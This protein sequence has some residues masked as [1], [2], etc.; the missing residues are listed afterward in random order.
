MADYLK[1]AFSYLANS[2]LV[3]NEN[4]FLGSTIYVGTLTLRIKRVIA[5]GG[6]GVVYE[7]QDATKSTCYALKRMLAHDKPTCDLILHEI[8]I[9]KQLS[10]HPNIMRFYSAASVGKEKLKVVGT[11]FLIV[12]EYCRG[13]QLTQYL[14]T[15]RQEKPFSVN[16]I[17]QLMHQ[18]CRAVQHMHSQS[19]PVMHRDLK[20]ENLLLSEEFVIK[21]C[22]FGSASTTSYIPD[23]SWSALKRSV[24][25]EELEKFTTPMYRAPEMLDLYQNFPIGPAADIWALGCILFYLTCTYHPFEDSAK[26]AILNAKYTLPTGS[27][28]HSVFHSLIRQM[29]LI[30]PRQRPTITEVL[31]ELSEL[32]SMREIRV[33]SSI[34]LADEVSKRHGGSSSKPPQP[35]NSYLDHV[36]RD[37]KVNS[38]PRLSPSPNSLRLTEH[39]SKPSGPSRPPPPAPP[40]PSSTS[41]DSS[42]PLPHVQQIA[43]PARVL[44][45]P[46]SAEPAQSAPAHPP[47]APSSGNVFGM[48]KGGAG[49]LFRNLRDA[50]NKV[51]ESVSSTL[52]GELDFQ[53]ITSRIIVMSYPNESG[54]EALGM[55][56]AMEE[57]QAMLNSRYP[58]SYAVYNL[59]PRAYRS[60]KWFDGR[61]SHRVFDSHRAP[62]LRSLLELC[63]NARL[64]LNQKPENVCVIHCT[65]G[66]AS[67]AVLV[68]ALLCFC[69]LFDNISPALQLFSSRRGNP[70]L[71][72]SQKRYVTYVAQLAYNRVAPPHNRPLSLI[73]LTIAPVPTFNKS[74]NGCRPYV[75]IYEGK[76]R[77]FSSFTDYDSLR[78]YVLEDGKI[79]VLLN[80]TV[81]IGDLCVAVYHCRSS[82]GGRSKVASVKIAQFQLFT[83]FVEPNETEII[84]FKSDL[85]HLDNSSGFAGFTSRYAESFHLTLEFMVSPKERPRQGN[86]LVFPWEMLPP[87]DALRPELCV[88]NAEEM[89]SLLADFGRF[90]IDQSGSKRCR[91]FLEKAEGSVDSSQSAGSPEVAS[92]S[93]PDSKP[94]SG[95]HDNSLPKL[96]DDSDIHTVE[97]KNVDTSEVEPTDVTNQPDVDIFESKKTAENQ[98]EHTPVA[99]LLGFSTEAPPR[100]SSGVLPENE[101]IS[102]VLI[103]V[104]SNPSRLPASKQDEISSNKMDGAFIDDL[105]NVSS[106]PAANSTATNDWTANF[107]ARDEIPSHQPSN[108][109]FDPFGLPTE[110]PE[111][112]FSIPVPVTVGSEHPNEPV[113]IDAVFGPS[114]LST[115]ASASNLN[116]AKPDPLFP[117]ASFTSLSPDGAQPSQQG[118]QAKLDPFPDIS[119]LFGRRDDSNRSHAPPSNGFSAGPSPVHR[120]SK[121]ATPTPSANHTHTTTTGTGPTFGTSHSS[122]SNFAAGSS[123]TA[124]P[125]STSASNRSGCKPQFGRDAFSDLLGG[126]GNSSDPQDHPK[127]INEMRR[128]QLAKT[129]DPDQLKVYDWANGKDR[130]LRALLC[131]LPA[132]LWEGVRWKPVGIADLMTPDQVKRQYRNAARAI[133]PDKW[134]NTENEKMAR[135]VFIEL[136]DAMA[137]FEKEPTSAVNF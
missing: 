42:V 6:Y 113:D 122:W 67:S 132:I 94:C 39:R 75:E 32:A 78:S 50:S 8:N 112:N 88:S 7:A 111:T 125:G 70:H 96:I 128:E 53:A 27:S 123:N 106:E 44:T 100:E 28:D 108:N 130:N 76:N 52:S 47:S 26:L 62:P 25:Q 137:E 61:V 81:V 105:F 119:D 86:N 107:E 1:S 114:H 11:E 54:L 55:G 110:E 57:V 17:I 48:F 133:H 49:N 10:G 129:T 12:T 79:E 102:S 37:P 115:S 124:S 83:G 95:V 16:T 30:D 40:P 41:C 109:P 72:A 15:P 58:N 59:S 80:G 35:A 101:D 66:R 3:K 63:L 14:P 82:F 31:G 36:G 4:E 19:P 69:H 56:N 68:C 38:T 120:P 136:N 73:S 29:L 51:L 74:K 104:D 103:D 91:S 99:D 20:I 45:Q 126:F 65:D 21:L 121:E 60:D 64:W 117:S 93:H 134:I 85:D 23:P 135:L 34:P 98:K 71:N 127:S 116:A 18:T 43:Q 87:E 9:L 5:E 89:Q 2:S 46:H 131:S 77:V 118:G 33:S 97:L 84:Y 90:N 24:V 92:D 13:G 22:D